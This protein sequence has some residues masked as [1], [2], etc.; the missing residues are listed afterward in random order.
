MKKILYIHQYFITPWEAGGTRSYWFSRELLN[1]NFKVVMITSRSNQ[2]RLV[3]KELVDGIDVIFIKNDY[4]NSFG[5]IRRVWSFLRF[6]ILSTFISFK[7]ENI[8]LVF[9]TSTP[10]T[11]GIP[12]VLL[13][14]IKGINY[15]FEVRDLWPEVPI[16]MGGVNNKLLISI[17]KYL[18]KIIYNNAKHIIA[19]SPGMKDGVLKVGIDNKKVSMIPNMSKIDQFGKRVKNKVLMDKFN[20]STDD[21]YIIHFGAMGLANGLDYIIDAAK[22]TQSRR[23]NN[24]KYLFAGEGGQ[25]QI[26]KTRVEKEQINNVIFLGKFKMKEMAE[27]VNIA[28]CSITTFRNLPILQTN[29]PNKL[30]DSLSAQKPII[31]N[32]AGWTK[33]LVEDNNCGAFVNPEDPAELASLVLS[34]STKEALLLEMGINSRELAEYVYDKSILSRE[35]AQLICN[36]IN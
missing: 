3:Q 23:N 15:V 22:I 2:D 16:Q 35:F 17:L 19:L 14:W 20:L 26:L 21:F 33:G 1:N 32:S 12:P 18:E 30:F 9:A 29:S 7:Q 25:E 11:V 10:L 31:V 36:E 8:D 13:K 6:M 27:I 28:D 34:W 5:I 24:I 4:D